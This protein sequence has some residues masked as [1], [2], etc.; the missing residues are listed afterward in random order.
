M[1]KHILFYT[2]MFALGSYVA[3]LFCYIVTTTQDKQDEVKWKCIEYK[4]QFN[5]DSCTL[6]RRNK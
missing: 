2:L 1:R 4:G 6:Y 5:P 3:L